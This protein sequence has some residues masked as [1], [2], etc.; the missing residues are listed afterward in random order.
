S[1]RHEREV[2][3][4]EVVAEVEVAREARAGEEALAPRALRALR[5]HEVVDAALHGRA[6]DPVRGHEAEE[7]PRR[8]RGRALALPGERL[9]V[10]R[11][12]RLAPAAV[13]VL[14]RSQPLDGAAHPRCAQ[15]LADRGEAVE[16]GPGAVDEVDAP[17]APP[18]AVGA[19]GAAYELERA[20]GAAEVR[21]V[22]RDA[23]QVEE[24]P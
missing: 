2:V 10:V 13:G 12:D 5:A 1:E 11:G 8:L 23:H 3:P 4:V 24:P 21:A 7:R 17:A 16:H 6:R 15:V 22:A 18:R 14:A 19:L 9:V 20:P